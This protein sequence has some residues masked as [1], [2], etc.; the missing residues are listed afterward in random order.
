MKYEQI[1]QFKNRAI[2]LIRLNKFVT[3]FLILS[4]VIMFSG[5]KDT[6]DEANILKVESSY[7]EDEVILDNQID[8]LRDERN[9]ALS[10]ID[11]LQKRISSLEQKQVSKPIA[12][13]EQQEDKLAGLFKSNGI[14]DQ[15][16][17]SSSG[18][19]K[20]TNTNKSLSFPVPFTKYS[21]EMTIPSGS[22]VKA[23]MLTGMETGFG[24]K[25]PVLIAIDQ[26]MILPNNYKVDL[27]GC[28]ALG[29]ASGDES[30][31]RVCI[32]IYTLACFTQEGEAIERKMRAFIA[33]DEDSSHCAI[34]RVNTKGHKAVYKSALAEMISGAG[35]ILQ[36]STT[37]T[38]LSPLGSIAKTVTGSGI[39]SVIGGGIAKGSQTM[40]NWW[41]N[42]ANMM[43]PSIDVKAGRG[44]WLVT[45]EKFKV[46]KKFISEKEISDE[47]Y[48]SD[49]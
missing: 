16:T 45:L 2:T 10:I 3:F 8:F 7:K 32:E 41:L 46:P 26:E 22:R 19:V 23:T 40:A 33:D 28:V 44:I 47:E 24:Q 38:G 43:M 27:K 34:G 15:V 17:S 9:T 14:I 25:E 35:K 30:K 20:K 48:Y 6:V 31:E 36:A 42:Q 12:K 37:L 18:I 49:F 11:E 39:K 4:L 1:K 21:G 13:K 29:K 5:E